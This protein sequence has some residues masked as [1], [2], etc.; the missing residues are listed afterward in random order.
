MLD[1]PLVL[2]LEASE[3]LATRTCATCMGQTP[4]SANETQLNQ[5]YQLCGRPVATLCLCM[6]VLPS[7][8]TPLSA[9]SRLGHITAREQ[10]GRP[11]SCAVAFAVSPASGEP[12]TRL[13]AGSMHT[14]TGPLRP[15]PQV[16]ACVACRDQLTLEPLLLA[17][18][19]GKLAPEQQ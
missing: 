5:G 11:S 17:L 13:S 16:C 4:V 6:A 7:L 9:C 3:C 14:A 15:H 8:S 10:A 19:S 18:A 1:M 12:H 2:T